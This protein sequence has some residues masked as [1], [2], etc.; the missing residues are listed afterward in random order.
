MARVD[1][2]LIHG[3]EISP[4]SKDIHV[5]HLIKVQIWFIRHILNLHSCS[6]ITPLF[7]ETGIT[8]IRVRRL[9]IV[10]SHLIYFLGLEKTHYAR[11]ALD[12]S[13]ELSAR[14]KK[15]WAK[16]L[17]TAASRL[18]FQCPTLILDMS[19]TVE[20]VQD[21]AK[22]VDK[23]MLEW[24]QSSI[25]SSA[26]LYLLH[27][28]LEPQ[29]DTPPMQKTSIMRHYLTMVKTQKHRETLTSILLSTHQLAVEVLRYVDHAYKP[30]PRANRLCRLCK[31][32]IETPEHAIVSCTSSDKLITLCGSFLEQLFSICPVLQRVMA[33]ESE[34]EFLKAMIHSRPTI[35]LVAKFA[36]DVL[37]LFYAL[38][39]FC[40]NDA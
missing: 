8:P 2:H 29:K 35:A 1:C 27:G 33:T 4:D 26:K 7:M 16:D 23:L 3:C 39:V 24:L 14:G 6:M 38:P 32:E 40:L 25:D 5:K 19:T 31:K 21:Y 28:R 9:Q 34:I 30:V 36:Y 13:L 37:E 20:Y 15:S 11:A 18:P 22:L 12:S 17:T 10:L